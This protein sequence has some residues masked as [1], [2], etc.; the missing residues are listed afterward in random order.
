MF[1]SKTVLVFSVSIIVSL[2]IVVYDV[3]SLSHPNTVMNVVYTE[4]LMLPVSDGYD[5]EVDQNIAQILLL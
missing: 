3:R 1:A 4:G 2:V 5:M